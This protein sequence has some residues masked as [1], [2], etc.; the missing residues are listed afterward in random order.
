MVPASRGFE[1]TGAYERSSALVPATRDTQITCSCDVVKSP[2]SCGGVY[3]V[4][5]WCLFVRE[6]CCRYSKRPPRMCPF[7][8]GV[9]ASIIACAP[10]APMGFGRLRWLVRTVAFVF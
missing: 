2:H 5:C 6:F 3:P 4:C 1:G 10:L 7:V 8:A 9:T